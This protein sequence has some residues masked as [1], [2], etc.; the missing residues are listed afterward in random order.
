MQTKVY[1]FIYINS[2]ISA[3]YFFDIANFFALL[4][5]YALKTMEYRLNNIIVLCSEHGFYVNQPDENRVDI[6]IRD[7][8]VLSFINLVDEQDTIVGFDGTPWHDHGIVQFMTGPDTYIECDELD[9]IIGLVSGELLIV[10]RFMKSNLVD[11]WIIHKNEQLNLKYIEPG[12]E[13]KVYR[14]A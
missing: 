11:R 14:L 13:L 7:D 10:S 6:Q 4:N 12:E 1:K 9:I 5:C 8:C 3:S 2:M